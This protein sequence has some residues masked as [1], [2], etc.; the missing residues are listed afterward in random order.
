[1]ISPA[2]E[3]IKSEI[4]Q[5]VWLGNPLPVVV[6]GKPKHFTQ[7]PARISGLVGIIPPILLVSKNVSQFFAAG[8]WMH[9][10]KAYAMDWI[11]PMH[12]FKQLVETCISNNA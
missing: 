10:D 1:M 7:I 11:F 5:N 4:P 2:F 3:I 9:T 12:V 6:F 8:Y